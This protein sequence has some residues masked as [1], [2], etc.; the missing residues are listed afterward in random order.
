[1]NEFQEFMRVCTV[2]VHQAVHGGPVL[3]EIAF[4]QAVGLVPFQA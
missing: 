4:L 2:Q 3:T 1:M